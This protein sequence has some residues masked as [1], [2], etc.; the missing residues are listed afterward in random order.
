LRIVYENVNGNSNNFAEMYAIYLALK[1]IS[2][3][4]TDIVGDV[5][6]FTDSSLS[7][8]V[9]LGNATAKKLEFVHSLIRS[10]A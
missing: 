6:I 2:E 4:H 10:E 3:I 1:C 7:R 5:H 9:L 8:Q